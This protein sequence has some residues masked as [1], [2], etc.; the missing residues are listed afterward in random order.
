M[1]HFTTSLEILARGGGGGS[2]GGSS[3][4]DGLAL[5]G[6]IPPYY[7]TNYAMKKFGKPGAILIGGVTTFV[8][9][10][11]MATVFSSGLAFLE[12]IAAFAGFASGYFGLHG[13]LR[14]KI[15]K[16][17]KNLATA[18]SLDPA[19]D[20]KLLED[21]VSKVF[22]QYQSDWMNM[23]TAS[24]S[25]YTTKQ[26]AYHNWLMLSA[27]NQLKRQN[28]LTDVKLKQIDFVDIND[29]SSNSTD[30]FTVLITAGINDSL[31]DI[32]SQKTIYT[33]N[34]DFQEY[35]TFI[36]DDK[37]GWILSAITQLTAKRTINTAKVATFAKE[38][39]LYF[40]LDWGWLLL[41]K[42]GNIF[43][44]ADF[45]KS[46]INNHCIGLLDNKYLIQLYTYIPAKNNAN[47]LNEII[48][49][50]LAVPT[51][52]Y[53]RIVIEHKGRFSFFR[54]SPRGLHRL[55]TESSELNKRFH[56]FAETIEQV[57]TFELLNPKYMQ[58]LID[59]P[60][61][62]NIEVYDNIIFI[63]SRD[64]KANYST[65]FEFLKAAY[66]ELKM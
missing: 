8:W 48:V 55:Q 12:T 10:A 31:F 62:F 33:D 42:L 32:K 41:P 17:K 56:I 13:K 53:G 50:Q 28:R 9:V 30:N 47:N 58:N 16:S 35:W 60:G 43:S 29:A 65:L 37:D 15:A 22:Y 64:K 4:G 27:L 63:Y 44:K 20:P 6:Y 66:K 23:D 26:F 34:S 38:N 25:N 36:R 46:D 57:T 52:S 24:I 54:R 3:G 11:L 7:A 45:K 49:A 59:T 40:S 18:A 19:W 61:K 2:G 51:K 21:R 1:E 14:G 5:I 39:S